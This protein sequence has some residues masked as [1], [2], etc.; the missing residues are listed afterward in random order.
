MPP[1]RLPSASLAPGTL[2][3]EELFWH[4]RNSLEPLFD[5]VPLADP[6]DPPQPPQTRQFHLGQFLFV[7]ARYSR[8]KFVRDA[9][10][11]R[12]HD[13][14][15]HVLIQSFISG[16]NQADNEGVEY[17]EEPGGI[18]AVNLGYLADSICTD[19]ETLTLV[20]PREWLAEQ[21][22]VLLD[23]RGPL[24]AKDGMA[25]RLFADFMVS[26]R[27]NL[28]HATIDD[29]PVL[30]R[31][32]LGLLGS[33]LTHEDPNA[34]D[35]RSGMFMAIQRHVDDNLADPELGI[36]GLCARFRLSRA[37]LF[38]LFKEHGG[39]QSYIQRRRLMACFRAL[40]SPRQLDRPIYDTALDH[41]LANPSHLSVLFR[42]HFGM[43]PREVREAARDRHRRGG[44]LPDFRQANSL[45][46][47]EVMRLWARELGS[48]SGSAPAG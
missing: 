38:R 23:A 28:P 2:S 33:M 20:L 25:A 30:S 29:A 46:D 1:E 41:G 26:L 43:S 8:Q 37:T 32:L 15:D 13:D 9:T 27:R 39:V 14:S 45:P 22:P 21:L 18:F 6:R 11:A 42:Q 44:G 4:W 17:V 47:V 48:S 3:N 24:F 35:A 5:S 19:A 40:N 16:R 31:S 36:T 10:W 12:R 7:E 34:A